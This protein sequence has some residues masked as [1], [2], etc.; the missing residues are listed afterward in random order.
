MTLKKLATRTVADKAK[1]LDN[2]IITRLISFGFS[3]PESL[4]YVYLLERG[5]EVGGSKIAIGTHLH[6]QYV[7]IALPKLIERGVVEE[8]SFG[9]HHKY[10]ARPPSEIDKLGRKRALE[11]SD[12]AHDLSSISNVGNEQDFEMYVGSVA[13]QRY[14]YDWVHSVREKESQY[15]IGGNTQGFADMMGETLNE[16]LVNETR[17]YITTYYIGSTKEKDL[18]IKHISEWT[19]FDIRFLD[20]LPQGATHMVIRKDQVLFFSFLKPALLY[21]IKSPVVALNYKDFFMML[22][23]MAGAPAEAGEMH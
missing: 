18:Y 21:V 16:Y 5:S 2:P 8:V 9:K 3:R 22:W 11:A 15:I 12:L 19:D 23:E 1:E 20:K 6:R 14:E 10:K 17:K 7:Y 4:I 13:I